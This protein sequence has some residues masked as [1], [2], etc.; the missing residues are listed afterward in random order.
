VV[1]APPEL[2]PPLVRVAD[3][4]NQHGAQYLLIASKETHRE[5]DAVDL[6]RLKELRRRRAVPGRG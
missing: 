4:L 1:N 5:Q 6:L 3:L 2:R